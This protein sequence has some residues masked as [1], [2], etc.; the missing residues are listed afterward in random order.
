[1]KKTLSS[2][3]L[4]L[5]ASLIFSGGLLAQEQTEVSIKVTKDGKV[6]QDT[7]YRFDNASD[8]RDVVKMI[9]VLNGDDE[10][11]FR[12]A[13]NL[14]QDSPSSY[15]LLAVIAASQDKPE[16]VYEN[17]KLAVEKCKNPQMMKD[18]AKKD[19]EFAKLF[20]EAEFKAIVE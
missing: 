3:I 20:E 12:T 15:Y 9:E 16:V 10:G 18:N 17:L 4:S 19:I 5:A 11:A 1:M 6:I 13:A 14:E 7:T 2:L 8:A